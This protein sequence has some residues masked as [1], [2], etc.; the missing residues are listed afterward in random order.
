MKEK[1]CQTCFWNTKTNNGI[2]VKHGPHNWKGCSDYKPTSGGETMITFNIV[3]VLLLNDV[4]PSI[5]M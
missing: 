4:W 3:A 5:S 2:C 1:T